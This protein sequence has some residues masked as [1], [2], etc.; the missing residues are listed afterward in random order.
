MSICNL[1]SDAYT[2]HS[3]KI[4]LF[5]NNIWP[6]TYIYPKVRRLHILPEGHSKNDKSIVL[7]FE[8][9]VTGGCSVSFVFIS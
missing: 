9:R 2:L 4:K 7:A 3:H 1:T 8:L 5:S 6:C